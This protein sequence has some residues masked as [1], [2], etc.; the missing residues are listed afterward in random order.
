MCAQTW[1]N[2][3][4]VLVKPKFDLNEGLRSKNVSSQD[5]ARLSEVFYESMGMSPLTQLFWSGSRLD[6]PSGVD[7]S[8][9][10]TAANLYSDGDY[11]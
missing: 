9:H 1:E 3:L 10:G 4:D 8:C 6:G 7:G 2:L 11:R 5:M